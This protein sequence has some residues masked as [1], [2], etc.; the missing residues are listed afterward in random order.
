MGY[1]LLQNVAKGSLVTIASASH[2][3]YFR[4][5]ENNFETSSGFLLDQEE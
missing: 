4:K 2:M 3:S 5:P 1:A